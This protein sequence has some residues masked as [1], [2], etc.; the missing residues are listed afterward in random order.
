MKEH[1]LLVTL[2]PGKTDIEFRPEDLSFLKS[3]QEFIERRTRLSHYQTETLTHGVW[4]V[5]SREEDGLRLKQEIF[6]VQRLGA[7]FIDAQTYHDLKYR[8]QGKEPGAT[9]YK[10]RTLN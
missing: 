8:L 9:P 1:F 4:V 10:P 7:D 5:R 6:K 3:I 2:I